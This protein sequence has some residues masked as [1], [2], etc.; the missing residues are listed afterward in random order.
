MSKI[1]K[2]EIQVDE[3]YTLL[4]GLRKMHYKAYKKYRDEWAW[5]IRMANGIGVGVGKQP[6]IEKCMIVIKR[7]SSSMPDW[8]NLYGGFKPLGDCL[9][10]CSKANPSGLGIIKNDSVKHIIDLKCIPIKVPR[11]KEKTIIQILK[12]P[13]DTPS[14]WEVDN[15]PKT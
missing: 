12:L 7:Y 13:D 10:V 11:G 8:D 6:P 14:V 1:N 2:I 4:N 3:A 9:V 5:K 15:D